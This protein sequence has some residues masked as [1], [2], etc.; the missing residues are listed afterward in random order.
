MSAAGRLTPGFS[1]DC[2]ETLEEIAVQNREIFLHHGG[3]KFAHIP[4]MNDSPQGM[5]VITTIVLRELQ[6]WI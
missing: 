2:L 1:A 3:E 5:R 6:G 4:C